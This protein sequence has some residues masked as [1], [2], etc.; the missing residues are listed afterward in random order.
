MNK[1]TIIII[2]SLL[3]AL[4][5]LMLCIAHSNEESTENRLKTDTITITKR[6]TITITKPVL[7]TKYISKVI[8]DTLITRDSIKV[9]VNIPIE[10]KIYQQDST[11]RAV[12][13]GYR[14]SL[15]SLEIY[16]SHT[17]TTITNTRIKKSR[18]NVGI[19]TGIGYGILNKKTDLYVGVGISYRLF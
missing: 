8:T 9:E 6:D 11:Y 17:T 2:L 5:L 13:S 18:W 4:S 3:F 14:V 12:V 16:P 15:D 1:N 7:K 10:T 19:Q